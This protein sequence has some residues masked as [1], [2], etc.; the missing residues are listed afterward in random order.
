MPA[1]KPRKPR[2]QPGEAKRDATRRHLLERALELFRDRGV[3]ATTMRDIARAAGLSLGAAYYYFPSKE[4]LVFA[5]YEANQAE[6]EQLAATATGSVRDRLGAVIHGKLRSIREHRHMLGAIVQRLVDPGDP[7]SAF[8]AQTLAVR[9]RAIAVFERPLA[10]SGLPPDTIALVSR[11]MWLFMLAMM[12]LYVHDDSPEQLRTH[13]LVDDALDLMVPLL[14]VL[15]TPMGRL[16]CDQVA[17]ALARAGI[18]V[19]PP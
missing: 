11:A 18:R 14:P 9:D 5:F 19:A 7:L 6:I 2:R 12:L 13:G 15:A 4:A 1:R 16:A 17:V 8:S 10:I 3:E